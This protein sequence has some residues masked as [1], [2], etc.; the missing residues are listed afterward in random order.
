MAGLAAP[1]LGRERT[2]AGFVLALALPPL[3]EWVVFVAGGDFLA[4]DVLLQLAGV[5]AVALVGGLWPALLG[6][7]WSSLVLNYYSTQPFG[8]LEIADPENLLTL[9]IFVTVAVA[10]SLVVGLAARRSRE[11][12]N[13]SADAATLGELARG[14]LA[15]EDTV[16]GFLHHVRNH[17]GMAG[18]ALYARGDEQG[19]CKVV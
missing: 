9:V 7:F 8:S 12:A 5:V 14:V 15:A 19:V 11:A 3:L 18:A 6:A 1:E 10:V 17:F 16:Q 13:A 4:V 2:L